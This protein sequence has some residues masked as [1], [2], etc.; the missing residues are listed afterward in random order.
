MSSSTWR[1][2]ASRLFWMGSPE[3][4]NNRTGS[5]SYRLLFISS[6]IVSIAFVGIGVHRKQISDGQ[7]GGAIADM[8]ALY[9]LF[10]RRDDNATFQ[11]LFSSIPALLK[12]LDEFGPLTTEQQFRVLAL[13]LKTRTDAIELKLKDSSQRQ[14]IQNSWLAWTTVVGTVFWGFGDWPTQWLI[15]YLQSTQPCWLSHL[16]I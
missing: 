16:L 1:K 12:T 14:E 3:T 10:V 2:R 8:I 13:D 7:R 4:P 6:L 11:I 15:T 5:A 9:V